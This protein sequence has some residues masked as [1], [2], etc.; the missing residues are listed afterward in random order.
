MEN[1]EE[2]AQCNNEQGGKEI[3]TLLFTEAQFFKTC[4]PHTRSTHTHPHSEKIT[5]EK[6]SLHVSPQFSPPKSRPQLTDPQ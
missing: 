1:A 3:F 4:C 2:S 6:N 5:T